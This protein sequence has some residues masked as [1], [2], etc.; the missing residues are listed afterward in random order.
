MRNRSARHDCRHRD[1]EPAR[2]RG[3]VAASAAAGQIAAGEPIGQRDHLAVPA[4]RAGLR[5]A[6]V[7]D[8][9]RIQSIDRPAARSAAERNQVG[10][11]V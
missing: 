2:D 4:V 10:V 8:A 9:G 5:A 11:A 7:R 6:C 1:H 3:D